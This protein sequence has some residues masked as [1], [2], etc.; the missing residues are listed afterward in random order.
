MTRADAKKQTDSMQIS[1]ASLHKADNMLEEPR[2]FTAFKETLWRSPRF[3]KLQFY[4]QVDQ[5]TMG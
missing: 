3:M 2:T 5:N 1:A 4:G